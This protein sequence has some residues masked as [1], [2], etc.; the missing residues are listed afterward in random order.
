M[1]QHML[2]TSTQNVKKAM[3]Y[4][5]RTTTEIKNIDI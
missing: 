2:P 3:A 4:E 5:F 1:K